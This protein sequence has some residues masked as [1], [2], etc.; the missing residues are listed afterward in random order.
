MSD[1]FSH[2]L[3]P[4]EKIIWNGRPKTGII[5][6]IADIALIPFGLLWCCFVIL[7]SVDV[8]TNDPP[9]QFSLLGIPFLIIGFF[10]AFGRFLVDAS[11][12]SK[13]RYLVTDQRVII[14][15]SVLAKSSISL[16]ITKLPKIECETWRDGSGTILFDDENMR[17]LWL[18]NSV[19]SVPTSNIFA[20]LL[21]SAN[22]APQFYAIENVLDVYAIILRQSRR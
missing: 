14:I 22:R 4:N 21:P 18:A 17:L 10:L 8:W 20:T 5:F 16:D 11:L 13:T 12:R 2:H 1:D 15:K 6:R 7:L 9:M 3:I 19:F